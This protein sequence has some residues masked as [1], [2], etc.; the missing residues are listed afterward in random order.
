MAKSEDKIIETKEETVETTN[1]VSDTNEELLAKILKAQEELDKKAEELNSKISE[2]DEKEKAL[3]A[4]SLE[5]DSKL[6]ELPEISEKELMEEALSIGEVLKKE[7]Q[8]TIVV[9]KSELNP[10]DLV[11]P[12]TINGYT[13]QIKRGESVSVPKTVVDIL[14]EAK[15]I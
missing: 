7:E 9:P 13:Y 11:V 6:K 5:I 1:Q 15:Y 14:K 4:K 2:L 3:D 8:V 10:N 12:V